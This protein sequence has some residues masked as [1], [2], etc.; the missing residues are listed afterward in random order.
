M[1]II[2]KIRTRYIPAFMDV[3]DRMDRLNLGLMAAGVG[4]FAMLAIF[5][6]LAVVVMLWSFVADPAEIGALLDISADV[7]PPEVHKI[8]SDQVQGVIAAASDSTLGL[9]TFLSLALALWSARAGVAALIRGLNAVYRTENREGIVRRMAAAIGLTLVLCGSAIVAIAAVVIA[10]IIIALVPLGPSATMAAEVARW[11][12]ALTVIIFSLGL[13]YRYGPN[14]RKDRPKWITPGAVAA[15]IL[16]LA[17]SLA[18]SAYL[19]NFSNYNEVYGSI[20]AAVALLMWFYLSAYV[21]LLGAALN[22]E[23]DPEFRKSRREAR[24][25]AH[26]SE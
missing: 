23:L 20:G 4:F 10:P 25:R 16:W 15:A 8:L 18:F 6:A 11:V 14:K 3:I 7:L 12:V 5:P 2:A 19:S 13:I 1:A 9:A 21:V 26:V 22:V 17:V 24:A